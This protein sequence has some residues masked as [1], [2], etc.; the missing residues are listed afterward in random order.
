M[1]SEIVE[2]VNRTEAPLSYT[3][4]GR[5]KTLTPG[6]NHIPAAHVRFA[7]TQNVL[8][9]SE[10]PLNPTRFISLVGVRK[11]AKYPCT[12]IMFAQDEKGRVVAMFEDGETR[13]VS[14]ERIDRSR[15]APGRQNATEVAANFPISRYNLGPMENDDRVDSA[16]SSS[17]AG[18]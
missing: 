9:G 12:P 7:L 10:D 3:K 6:P 2:V 1:E 14:A 4:N 13:I 8:G 17:T 18:E 11:N 16:F 15:L 5:Q